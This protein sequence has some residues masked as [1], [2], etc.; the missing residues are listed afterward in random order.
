M[1]SLTLQGS[2]EGKYRITVRPQ[3]TDKMIFKNRWKG[4]SNSFVF[5]GPVGTLHPLFMEFFGNQDITIVGIS[6]AE[7]AW[8]TMAPQSMNEIFPT[9][10]W[11]NIQNGYG[12]LNA[13]S[14]TVH[15]EFT[16]E[17]KAKHRKN[18]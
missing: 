6:D 2:P 17:E 12:F 16:I 8:A 10:S 15:S 9:E 5:K 3:G 13:Y 14:E 7:Y 11:S 4:Y 18:H 1:L